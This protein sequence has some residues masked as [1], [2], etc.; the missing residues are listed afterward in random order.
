MFTRSPLELSRAAENGRHLPLQ[1]ARRNKEQVVD[2]LAVPGLQGAFFDKSPPFGPGDD[3]Q[4]VRSGRKQGGADNLVTARINLE[5]LPASPL[6]FRL[7]GQHIEEIPPS[8][9]PHRHF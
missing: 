8:I 4:M 2:P 7:S 5:N 3:S 6:P 9:E 1:S